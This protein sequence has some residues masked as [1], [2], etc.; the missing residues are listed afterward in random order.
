MSN[1]NVALVQ[2]LYAAFG[3]GEI[4]TIVAAMAADVSWDVVGRKK[5]YPIFGAWK[6]PQAV[7]E[8]FRLVGEQQEASEFSPR[9]FHVAGDMV[10][11]LGHYAWK[12]RKTGRAVSAD[13]IHAFTIKHGKVVAFRE[14]TDTAQFAEAFRG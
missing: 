5:D 6:G 14:F 13:W 9:D 1:A 7:Q 10:F 8:F 3:R 11:V 4:A 2:S 12:L